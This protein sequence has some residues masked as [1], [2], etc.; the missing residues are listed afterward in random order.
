MKFSLW[1]FLCVSVSL[2]SVLANGWHIRILLVALCSSIA[3]AQSHDSSIRF[4]ESRLASDPDDFTAWNRLAPL[5]LQ[6]LRETGSLDYLI[7]AR[8]AVDRSLSINPDRNLIARS[9]QC[10]VQFSSH[11]FAASRDIAKQLVTAE[12]NQP[13]AHM[14]LGDA[15][16]E[17]G[18]YA[19]A[20]ES[21]AKMI[22]LGGPTTEALCRTAHAAFL[23]GQAS[24]ATDKFRSALDSAQLQSPPNSETV[25]WI[26]CQLSDVCFFTG[27][28][29][30]AEARARDALNAFPNYFRARAA[31]AR[32]LAAQDKFDT[33]ITE[34][35]KSIA[36]YPDPI[37][38]AALG[39]LYHLTARERDA[40]SQYHL[41]EQIT[42]LNKFAGILYN[43]NI[44]VFYAN[45]DINLDLAYQ[46][47]LTEYQS[48]KD[49]YGA[50]ALAWTAYKSHHLDEARAAIA[51]SLKLHTQDPT[52]FYHAGMIEFTAGSRPAA[53][54]Y[55][56]Q[57]LK[58][59]PHFDPLQLPIA[60]HTLESLKN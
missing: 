16:L 43:R 31:L 41:I 24:L 15:Y 46:M 2:E 39:D 38:I 51:E 1:H 37:S 40:Q 52:L 30:A 12:P 9:I 33:A 57:A 44:A 42:K 45:H 59:S 32:T 4:L 29:P 56:E 22:D 50:D 35:E 28:Y 20:A 5:Y 36:T 55:P 8:R 6:R 47:A 3:L 14:Y 7:L 10:R 58:L 26:D 21:Y 23:H 54:N 48:R 13:Y 17:L 19:A 11:E 27:D 34:Y 49:I 18:D 60:R 25:A 53:R